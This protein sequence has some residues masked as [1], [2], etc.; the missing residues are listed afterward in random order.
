MAKKTAAGKELLTTSPLF[1]IPSSMNFKELLDVIDARIAAFDEV[2][3]AMR[4]HKID[5]ATMTKHLNVQHRLVHLMVGDLRR[6]LC[7]AQQIAAQD[8]EAT[9]QATQA[10]KDGM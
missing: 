10:Q 9:K 6:V 7:G 5:L 2:E 8:T 1:F 3:E 4:L